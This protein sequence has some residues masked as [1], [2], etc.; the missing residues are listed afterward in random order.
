MASSFNGGHSPS[1]YTVTRKQDRPSMCPSHTY[2]LPP[3]VLFAARNN[4]MTSM[5][6]LKNTWRFAS[7]SRCPKK[8]RSLR[9]L[10]RQFLL[11]YGLTPLQMHRV[12]GPSPRCDMCAYTTPADGVKLFIHALSFLLGL[13]CSTQKPGTPKKQCRTCPIWM[14]NQK[15]VLV[16]WG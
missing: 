1:R 2:F 12:A 13:A 11:L 7:V 4:F 3:A 15:L 16:R 10:F 9:T 6:H 5:G 14:S 8:I